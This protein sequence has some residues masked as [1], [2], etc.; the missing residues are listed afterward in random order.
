MHFSSVTFF[1][2]STFDERQ[3]ML[4]NTCKRVWK[5]TTGCWISHK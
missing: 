4:G 3:G 2:Y 5:T 1:S